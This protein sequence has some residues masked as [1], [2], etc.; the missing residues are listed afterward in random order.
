MRT[1]PDFALTIL[2]LVIYFMFLN[3]YESQKRTI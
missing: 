3:T 1:Y 2:K